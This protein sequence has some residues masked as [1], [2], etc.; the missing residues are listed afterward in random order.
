MP[1]PPVPLKATGNATVSRRAVIIGATSLA[2]IVAIG[3]GTFVISRS[4]P[5]NNKISQNN[6]AAQN[7]RPNPN[8]LSSETV[9]LKCLGNTGGPRYLDGHTHDGTIGLAS[10]TMPPFTGTSW[11]LN[12]VPSGL[13]TLKCLGNIEGPRYLEGH[14][15]DGTVGLATDIDQ[16]SHS[17][18]Y[19]ELDQ[20][21]ERN[22]RLKCRGNKEGLRYLDG[23]TADGTVSL[24]APESGETFTGAT[25]RIYT[26]PHIWFGFGQ[27]LLH[28]G[29]P[30][31]QADAATSYVFA[32]SDYNRDGIPDLY[33]LQRSNTGTNSLEVHIL[34]GADNYQSFL[35]QKGTPIAQA[36]AATNYVFA[37]GDYNRDGIPDLYCLKYSNTGTNS[38][39]V[40]ILNGADNYQSFLLQTGTP[41]AQANI[42]TNFAF[43]VGDYNRDGIPDLYCL[44]HSNTSTDSLEVYILNGA[45]NY[46]SF[47]LQT[48]T[49]LDQPD[50][51]ANFAFAVGDYN[52]DGISDIYSLKSNNIG[53][54]AL[55]V[56]ILNVAR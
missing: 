14:A 26:S 35:L 7:H 12:R 8:L 33:C 39:E 32:V 50:I 54:N 4:K 13:Y 6:E 3:A 31:A 51:A 30:I 46:R 56:H 28:T 27:F 38:L 44:K 24:T 9:I 2:A 22:Y 37:V 29:T 15:V 21:S 5:L 18:T 16:S 20:S 19:W 47:L 11:E 25:W 34:N 49:V 36:D 48:G 23:H 17:G 41:I 53:T 52:R 42:P 55:E 1:A 43:A 40:H 45:D 10:F